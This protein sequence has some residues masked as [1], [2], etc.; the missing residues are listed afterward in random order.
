VNATTKPDSRRHPPELGDAL[1]FQGTIWT[2]VKAAG[3]NDQEIRLAALNILL[4]KYEA[5]MKACLRVKFGWR[6]GVN[7][8]CLE[9][10]F[11][12][13]IERKVM[14][15][16]L[17]DTADPNRGRFRDLLKKALWNFA[18]QEYRAWLR[19]TG[20]EAEMAEG[21]EEVGATKQNECPEA[22]KEW[23]RRVII[24]A[25]LEL[26]TDY[27]QGNQELLWII[28]LR[29]R[30][31]PLAGQEPA[32]SLEQTVA[33]V[34]RA[35][36]KVLTRQQISNC[37]KSAERKLNRCVRDVLAEY[38]RSEEDIEEE[39]LALIEI[40]RGGVS[41]PTRLCPPHPAS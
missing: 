27:K 28:F 5:P 6:P 39:L 22:E 30:L 31:F 32:E 7:R 36:G 12:S 25:L 20:N 34:Q 9:D 29:R 4:T 35:Y 11:Q 2:K 13:F 15:R 23:A 19:R 24:Q 41:L 33:Y 17:I 8:E 38:C 40:L 26:E 1:G 16:G 14:L 21:G 3:A 18:M 10:W 37:Q